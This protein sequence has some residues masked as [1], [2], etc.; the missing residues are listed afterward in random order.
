MTES[1]SFKYN[2]ATPCNMAEL[3]NEL[4][5]KKRID[6]ICEN[7]GLSIDLLGQLFKMKAK[8]YNNNDTAQKLGIHRVTVQRYVRSLKMMQESEFNDVCNF[9]LGGMQVEREI[10]N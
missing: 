8:G 3:L 5:E 9:V 4:K 1:E 7:H 2:N 10:N 6:E